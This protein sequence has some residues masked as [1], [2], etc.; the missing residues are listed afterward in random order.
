MLAPADA[1]ERLAAVNSIALLDTPP[2][3]PSNG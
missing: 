3:K 2:R 1:R